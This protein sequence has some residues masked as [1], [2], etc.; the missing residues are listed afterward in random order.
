MNYLSEMKIVHRDLAA[1]NLLLSKN[2]EGDL[3]V[4]VSDFGLSRKVIEGYYMSSDKS[5]RPVRWTAPV[6]RYSIAEI[7]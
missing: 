4:K 7:F 2:E 6:T 3:T 5:T 1:R